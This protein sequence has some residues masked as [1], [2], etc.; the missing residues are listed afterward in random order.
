MILPN[1]R[2]AYRTYVRPATHTTGATGWASA[3]TGVPYGSRLRLKSTYDIST[4]P[5]ARARTVAKALQTYGLILADGGNIAITAKSDANSTAKYGSLLGS[6]HL[7]ALQ[8]T[9]FEMVDGGQRFQAP[10]LDC[11]RNP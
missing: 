6:N 11:T 4:L 1:S 10:S 3:S 8:V 7:N 2:I 9:D 5:T